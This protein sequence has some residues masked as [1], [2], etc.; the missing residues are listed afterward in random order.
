MGVQESLFADH[1]P[2]G[3]TIS[4]DRLLDQLI[5]F[6]WRGR[7]TTVTE[8]RSFGNDTIIP[9]FTNE[10]WTSRQRVAHSLHEV[11]YRACFKPQLPAFFI[12]R[13]T[14]RGSYVY[15]P[16]AG[17]G[18]TLIE[19][20]LLG[21][22]VAGTDIN[23]LSAALILPRL[24]PPTSQQILERLASIS[25][26]YC[27]SIPEDL[28]A[29]YH[30]KTLAE[31]CALRQYLLD[32]LSSG[33]FDAI[34]NWIR[35]VA[36]NRL[37]GHSPGFLSVY[38]LPPNQAVSIAA[39]RKINADRNQVPPR[40]DV[41]RT[42]SRKSLALLADV[43]DVV[44]SLLARAEESARFKVSSCTDS[45]W[46]SEFVQLIVTSPPFLDV[47]DYAADNWLRCWFCGID[48]Q[49]V[50]IDIHPTLDGWSSFIE[51]AFVEFH[52]LLKPRGFVAFEVGEVRRG[53][54]Q[55]EN[56][57]VPSGAAAGLRPICIVVNEQVFTKTANIWG[58][59][60]NSKGTNS[61]RIVVF[62]KPA[63]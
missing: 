10:F 26:D 30:P 33:A 27:G 15:D 36:V 59:T 42:I 39:Q 24:S 61:N 3:D 13:L 35:M 63:G 12:E 21:R 54:I 48:A 47:V 2:A 38:T 1:A 8:H 60:N 37:T 28:L 11:S 32:R 29:F 57:V 43:D 49:S 22:A 40:R 6:R 18:T 50:A 31:I 17:R 34:D 52:R 14:Q 25:L 56:L 23:P 20:A 53:T 4:S 55:L 7:S 45:V 16:F 5:S 46:E 62:Q 51:R 44:R 9:I 19:A 41:R 58:V